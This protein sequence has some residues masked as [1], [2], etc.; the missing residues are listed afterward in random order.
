MRELGVTSQDCKVEV[1]GSILGIAR[2]KEQLTGEGALERSDLEKWA[3]VP[4]NGMIVWDRVLQFN[5][6]IPVT[7]GQGAPFLSGATA[8]PKVDKQGLPKKPALIA[9]AEAIAAGRRKAAEQIHQLLQ[10]GNYIVTRSE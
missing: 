3:D 5:T 2:V 10:N 6:P 1:T 4:P 9:R 7:G 8:G